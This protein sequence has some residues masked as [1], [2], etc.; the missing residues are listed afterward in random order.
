MSDVKSG[1]SDDTDAKER[2][3][4]ALEQ[5]ELTRNTLKR[6]QEEDEPR[7]SA[8]VAVVC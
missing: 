8:K 2:T 5:A 3:A 6:L 4:I 7:S 1:P